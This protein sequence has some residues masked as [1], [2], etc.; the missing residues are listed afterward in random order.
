MKVDHHT[1]GFR[2]PCRLLRMLLVGLQCF[3]VSSSSI[4]QKQPTQGPQIP[5]GFTPPPPTSNSLDLCDSSQP[6]KPLSNT[7]NATLIGQ[8]ISTEKVFSDIQCIDFCLRSLS[9]KA[10]N[11]ESRG[12]KIYCITLATVERRQEKYGSSCRVFDREKIEKFLF[13]RENC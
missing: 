12:S 9:C 1:L 4:P 5:T 7:F 13:Q 8:V 6:P 10:Y 3:S 11:M 2:K